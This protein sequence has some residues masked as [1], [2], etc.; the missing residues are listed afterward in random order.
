MSVVLEN[1]LT[2]LSMDPLATTEE[3]SARAASDYANLTAHLAA[4]TAG[5]MAGQRVVVVG[6]GVIGLMTALYLTRAGAQVELFEA[7]SLGAAASGRNAGGIYAFGRAIDEVALARASMDLWEDLSTRGIDSHFQRPGHAMI[8]L[9][10]HERSLLDLA[11]RHYALAGLPTRMLSPEEAVAML[12]GVNPDNAG[13][14]MGT[15]DGQGYPFTAV[16]SIIAELRAADAIIHDHCPVQSVIERG[17]HARGVRSERGVTEADHV[18]LCAGPWL[19]GFSESAGCN[20]AVRPRRS[21]LMVTERIAGLENFPFVS[22]NRVYARRTH[23]GNIMVGGGGPWEQD[24]YNVTSSYEALS[25]LGKHMSELFPGLAGA[26]II[27]AFAGTVELTADHL[28]LFG[29]A[30]AM[31]GL[32]ISAGYNGHGFGLCAAMGR[33]TVDLIRSGSDS[34]PLPAAVNAVV[35]EFGPDRFNVKQG[36]SH[37]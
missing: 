20:L 9:N 14:L 28:P 15:T 17:G 12:P 4:D 25:F 37:E 18:I 32:W 2:M 1:R 30:P 7:Q 23:A 29:P 3:E 6:G 13:A 16:T 19:A 26:P 8:A 35:G 22:G 10:D 27:R 36:N 24:G 34:V 11:E 33:L 31:A 21:Q 5:T